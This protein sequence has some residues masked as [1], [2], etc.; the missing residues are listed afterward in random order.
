MGTPCQIGKQQRVR[1]NQEIQEQTCFVPCLNKTSSTI[2]PKSQGIYS[3]WTNWSTCQSPDCTSKRTRYCLQEPCL[4]KFIETRS[5]N[6]N[7]C[8]SKIH[9]NGKKKT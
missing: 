5:C 6:T 7:S 2:L 1:N 4:Q 8:S 9:M 3:N